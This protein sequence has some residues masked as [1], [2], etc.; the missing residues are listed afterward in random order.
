MRTFWLTAGVGLLAG[1]LIAWLT[2][3]LSTSDLGGPGWS[4]RGNGA[5]VVEFSAAPA[6][7]AG[8]WVAFGRG[9]RAAVL[10][11]LLTLAIAAGLAFSPIVPAALV[12]PPLGLV[13]GLLVA[14]P[15][16]AAQVLPAALV[17]A[18]S[19]LV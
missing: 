6:V 14:R 17:A 1:L 5:L 7:L 10:A 8:G 19:M 15:R 11:G 16:G 2:L 3:W 9:W 4:L 12:G 18:V 13:A